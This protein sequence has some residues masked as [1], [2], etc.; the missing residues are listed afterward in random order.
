MF[1]PH[2]IRFTCQSAEGFFVC[3]QVLPYVETSLTHVLSHK[4]H[5]C[6]YYML[7]G[8]FFNLFHQSSEYLRGINTK[9][10]TKKKINQLIYWKKCLV[11]AQSL[12]PFLMGSQALNKTKTNKTFFLSLKTSYFIRCKILVLGWRPFC[13]QTCFKSMSITQLLKICWLHIHDAILSFC[14]ILKVLD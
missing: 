12:L 8:D 9:S 10:R 6:G 2:K 1:S 13:F 3:P 5:Q 7:R 4:V 14:H 11:S